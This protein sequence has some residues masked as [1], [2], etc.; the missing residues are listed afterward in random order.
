[1]I[2]A[3]TIVLIIFIVSLYVVNIT[4][5][6]LSLANIAN[7]YLHVETVALKKRYKGNHSRGNL[8]PDVYNDQQTMYGSYKSEIN[9]MNALSNKIP[10]CIQ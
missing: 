1:M 5:H 8:Y 6:I 10:T 7:Y 4:H 2:I 9:C 3:V